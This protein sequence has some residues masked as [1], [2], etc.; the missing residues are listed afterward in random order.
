MQPYH[1]QLAIQVDNKLYFAAWDISFC[2]SLP[3]NNTA[4]E[5]CSKDASALFM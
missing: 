3:D 4:G 5:K 1:Y 2:H